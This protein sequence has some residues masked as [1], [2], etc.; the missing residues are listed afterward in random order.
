MSRERAPA[1]AAPPAETGVLSRWALHFALIA[2][3]GAFVVARDDRS[4]LLLLIPLALAPALRW[5]RAPA[6]TVSLLPAVARVTLLVAFALAVLSRQL[7]FIRPEVGHAWAGGLGWVLAILAVVFILG[8]RLWPVTATLVPVVVGLLAVSGLDPG[9]RLFTSFAVV[10]ALALWA[11]AFMSGGPRRL[12]WPLAAFLGVS[13]AAAGGTMRFLPW[14]QPH[15]ERAVARTFAE[16]TTGLSEESRLGEFGELAV[17]SRVVLRVWTAEPRLLRAYVHSQFDGREWSSPR[18]LDMPDP[19]PLRPATGETGRSWL[20]EVPGPRFVIPPED[21][22]PTGTPG[23]VE[24]RVLQSEIRDWPLLVP[25]ATRLVRAPTSQ[26]TR[27][28]E[29]VLRW[30]PYEPARLYGAVHDAARAAPSRGADETYTARAVAL[31]LPGRLDPRVRVLARVL[32]S[33]AT[34]DRGRLRNTVEW[35]RSGYTYSLDVGAFETE[36]PLAE[37]LFDKKEGYCEYF[38]TAAAVLLRLQGVPARYVKGFS[39]GPQN[40]VSGRFGVGDHYL[41]RE[42]DAHAWIEAYI[43]GEGW[44]EADPTP[45]ADLS[46]LHEPAAGWLATLLEGLRVHAA[47]VWARLRHEGLGGV[48]NALTRTAGALLAGLGHHPLATG[49]LVAALLLAASWPWWR[50]LL[51][52][53]RSQRRAR[54]DRRAALPGELATLLSTVE[55]HWARQGRARP[56]SRGLREHLDGLPEGVLTPSAR[57]ASAAV[58]D[59]C[60]RSAFAGRPPSPETVDDLRSAVAR[61]S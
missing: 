12:G 27:S 59:A 44:V 19:P 16:G 38:A 43:A 8:H 33:D 51:L 24:T 14:A 18:H 15:V 37:F 3:L 30:P 1:P 40:F 28:R 22:L 29:G 13:A 20:T 53:L 4:V 32:E 57:E 10:G 9:V 54:L 11:F 31:G 7:L 39:V 26:L 61:M 6:W 34:S 60:Y 45:P 56:P 5:H 42:S 21:D 23:V 41:V 25:A 2:A 46:L 35:L 52:R 47:Q 55:R 50:A 48:W 49:G 36:D 58:V 17:S